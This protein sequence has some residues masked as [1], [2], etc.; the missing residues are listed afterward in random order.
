M[1][2]ARQAVILA[3]GR[4]ERMRP[5]T[6]HTPKPLLRVGGRS[7]IVHLIT[8]LAES[9]YSD[10]V[11]NHSYLGALIETELSDGRAHGVRIVYSPEPDGPLETGGG[12]HRALSFIRTDPFVV[13]N[14]DIWTDYPFARLPQTL[15]GLAHL[16]LV[17][18]PPHHAAGDFALTETGR[19][20]C[21]GVFKK[22]FSGIGVYRRALFSECKPGKFPLAPLL[23]SAATANAVSGEHYAGRWYD[24]GTPDRLAALD[25]ELQEHI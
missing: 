18:N 13:V 6:D 16:V 4:G 25:R 11:I 7:L 5:L 9:G 12:I 24:I 8:A 21:D 17:D 1:T 15:I 3:A 10:L 2:P 20:M 14:G 22:T 19:V 23:S